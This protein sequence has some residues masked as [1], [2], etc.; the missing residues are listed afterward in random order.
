M[1][2]LHA[3]NLACRRGGR[4]VFSGLGFALER[5]EALL[6]SGRNGAGKSSLLRLLALLTPRLR[7]SLWWNGID[8]AEQADTWRAAL[9]WLSH[10]DAIKADLTVRESLAGAHLL[11][12]GRQSSLDDALARFDLAPIADR[13][14]RY[15]S[16]GQRR[17]AALARVVSSGAPVWLLD[18]PAAGLDEPSRA[19]LHAALGAH[20]AA[21]GMAIIAS[22][23]DI[24]RPT[25]RHLDLGDFAPSTADLTEAWS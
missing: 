17:R 16:A 24:D 13:P 3:E 22:H 6:L 8:V 25:A 2:A 21:D 15:L 7:G 12:T 11:R 10:A 4:L 19:A 23:G 5:G 18:E 20:L 9:A 1:P 14:G